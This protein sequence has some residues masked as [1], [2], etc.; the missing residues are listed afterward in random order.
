MKK[1]LDDSQLARQKEFKA[2]MDALQPLS[3]D[4]RRFLSPEGFLDIFL[5]VR[6]DFTSNWEAYETLEDYHQALFGYRKYSEYDSFRRQY[7][8][9]LKKKNAH[10]K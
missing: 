1:K 7:T 6:S 2:R 9:A 4:A 8:R 5:K 3:D 10:K